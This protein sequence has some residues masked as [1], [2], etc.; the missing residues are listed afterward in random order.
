MVDL[1]RQDRLA[2]GRSFEFRRAFRHALFQLGV[3]L[4]K[5]TRLAIQFGEDFHLCPQ[6]FRDDGH[7][8]IIHR[9]AS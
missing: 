7:G 5:L 2:F 9:A 8:Y 4:L 1:A 3:Q 6:D